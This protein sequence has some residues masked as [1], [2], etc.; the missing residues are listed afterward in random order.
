MKACSFFATFSLAIFMA[1]ALTTE[2]HVRTMFR[3]EHRVHLPEPGM[4]NLQEDDSSAL[5][6]KLST[7]QGDESTKCLALCEPKCDKLNVPYYLQKNESFFQYEQ[8]PINC[9]L[10]ST[11]VFSYKHRCNWLCLYLF[12]C[13]R[14]CNAKYAKCYKQ[15]RFWKGGPAFCY[16]KSYLCMCTCLGKHHPPENYKRF[17]PIVG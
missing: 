3:P 5:V 12:D 11:V 14:A 10:A 8:T 1:N 17:P 6:S 2:E 13:C 15:L 7:Q 16:R 4:L 9:V